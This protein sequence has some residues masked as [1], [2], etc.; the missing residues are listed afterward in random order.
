MTRV[1]ITGG[2]GF[3]AGHLAPLCA[4]GGAEVT[5]V[6]R[7]GGEAPGHRALD[8]LDEAATAELV[9]EIVPDRVFHL[10]AQSSVARSWEDPR[11][12]I[13][14]NVLGTE[15]LL[16]A[17]TAQAPEARVLLAGSGDEYGQV[18]ESGLPI[19]EDHRLSPRS[20]YAYSK[21]AADVLGG[22]YAEARGMHVVRCRAF[23]HMGPG[24][25]AD[26]A[27]SAFAQQIAA[28]EAGRGEVVPLRTGDLSV[29]RD[30]TDVR[31]VCRAY[32]ALL[33]SAPP[34]AYNVCSGRSV[35]L[36]DIVESLASL[37]EVEVDVQTDPG[38]LRPSEIRDAYGSNARLVEATGWSPE[39]P[40]GDTLKDML[41]WWRRTPQGRAAAG[42]E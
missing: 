36:S 8:L 30:F 25:S 35:L 10:A 21:V 28:G 38:R 15:S 3:V 20:P 9:R 2:S 11:T 4:A 1:L 7:G 23:N 31:D 34:G 41:D 33:E 18:D 6:S 42:E 39:I 22:F 26:F 27:I 24:Q 29:R 14:T 17:L 13:V 32:R 19:T 5:L 40:L 12:T 16:G 37:A